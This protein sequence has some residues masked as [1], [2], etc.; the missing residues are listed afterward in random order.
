MSDHG[1]F[2]EWDAAYV[3]GMLTPEERRRFEEHLDD[4]PS[5]QAAVAELAG[6]PSMLSLLTNEQAVALDA[7]E[8][9]DARSQPGGDT[10]SVQ[11]LAR[12]ARQRRT[13]VRWRTAALAVA[14]A[15]VVAVAGVAVGSIAS[16]PPPRGMELA[17]AQVEPG[18]L[19][20][21]IT[22]SEKGWGTRFD[23]N[24]SYR[25]RPA[26]GGEPAGQPEVGTT[27]DLVVTDRAGVETRVASW[28]ASGAEA[29]NLSA[30]TS[31]P[32]AEIR[33]VDIRVAGSERPLVR[34][35]L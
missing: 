31:I 35:E 6:M 34:T 23:W 30:S 13:R 32:T 24:C 17:M 1:G 27:Y 9:P 11:H 29:G 18:W 25:E 16:A 10:V 21:D 15:V 5:C 28:T 20:A 26:Y 12:A 4:C 3:L 7:D 8:T 22:V 14:A 2:R 33:S 19:D